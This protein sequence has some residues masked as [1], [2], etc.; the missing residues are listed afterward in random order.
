MDGYISCSNNSRLFGGNGRV[1]GLLVQAVI[2]TM[3]EQAKKITPLTEKENFTNWKSE[4]K[5]VTVLPTLLDWE[6]ISGKTKLQKTH[7]NEHSAA[8]MEMWDLKMKGMQERCAVWIKVTYVLWY[9]IFLIGNPAHN[10]LIK[11]RKV[12]CHDPNQNK[13]ENHNA[14]AAP[15]DWTQVRSLPSVQFFIYPRRASERRT[16]KSWHRPLLLLC[17]TQHGPILVHAGPFICLLCYPV[18]IKEDRMSKRK[19]LSKTE[20]IP[21]NLNTQNKSSQWFALDDESVL[22]IR[23]DHGLRRNSI[24]L[25]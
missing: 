13:P 7:I 17:Y 22:I 12:I 2:A 5:V 16:K 21:N 9:E 14:T 23:T 4:E 19:I 18:L 1:T 6:P 25:F 8:E 10:R 24:Y 15:S 11:P 20:Q 3:A